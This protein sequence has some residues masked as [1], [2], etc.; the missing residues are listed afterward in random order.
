[1]ET[2]IWNVTVIANGTVTVTENAT[3]IEIEI[4]TATVSLIFLAIFSYRNN[5]KTLLNTF[6]ILLRGPIRFLPFR[7]SNKDTNNS[8]TPL[9]QSHSSYSIGTKLFENRK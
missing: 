4:H 5:F 1:M 9:F 2:G 6:F 8:F 7:Q 3:E